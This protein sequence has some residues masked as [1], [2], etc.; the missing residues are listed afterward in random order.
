MEV[1]VFNTYSDVDFALH[2]MDFLERP[3]NVSASNFDF[4]KAETGAVYFHEVLLT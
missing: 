4:E 1:I 2:C 3:F